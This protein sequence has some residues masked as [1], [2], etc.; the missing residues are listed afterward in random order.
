M[1]A[2]ALYIGFV[3]GVLI[4]AQVTSL[5]NF[6]VVDQ[7]PETAE[8]RTTAS[9]VRASVN[10]FFG[11]EGW[12]GPSEWSSYFWNRGLEIDACA[13]RSQMISNE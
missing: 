1:Q 13:L 3:T 2:N 6:P 4:V 11:E 10:A 9:V 7:Y 12:S 5:A 8:S